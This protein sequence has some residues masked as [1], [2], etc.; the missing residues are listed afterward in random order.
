MDECGD[1]LGLSARV[2]GW[3]E[4]PRLSLSVP[5]AT[6][7]ELSLMDVK[8]SEEVKGR[9]QGPACL[10]VVHLL[11]QL[12]KRASKSSKNAILE[13]LVWHCG[14]DYLRAARCCP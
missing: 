14:S 2:D 13:E 6:T 1:M 10:H 11:G 7:G 4:A 9:A 12:L 3:K 5:D 8:V